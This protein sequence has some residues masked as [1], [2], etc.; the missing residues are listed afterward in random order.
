MNKLTLAAA[1]GLSAALSMPTMAQSINA[2][3]AVQV[4]LTPVC[5]MTTP[6]AVTVNYTSFQGTNAV[7][8]NTQ[9]TFDVKCTT[10]LPYKV[11]FTNTALPGTPAITKSVSAS[12]DNLQLPYTLD[13]IGTT[14]G[15]GTGTTVIPLRVQATIN[16]G[17]SGTCAGPGGSNCTGTAE[18]HAVYVVY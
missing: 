4:V 13:L 9:G 14:S 6:S 5:V 16:S 10:S 2:N 11:G 3:V 8:A 12:A 15:T 1:L 18:T 7:S 17:L